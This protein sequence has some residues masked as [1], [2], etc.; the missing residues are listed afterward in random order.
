MRHVVHS[1]FD[2]CRPVLLTVVLSFVA[3]GSARAAAGELSGNIITNVEVTTPGVW[4]IGHD[5]SIPNYSLNGS[6]C[7]ATRSRICTIDTDSHAPMIPSQP[8]YKY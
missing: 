7:I 6:I 2:Q 5:Y 1:L 3:F 8:V 4:Q